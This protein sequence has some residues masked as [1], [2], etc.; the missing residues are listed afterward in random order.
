MISVIIPAHNAAAAIGECLAALQ[1]QTSPAAE[2][3]VIDD[4]STDN[5]AQL[6]A[7]FGVTLIR[8]PQQGP[9][10][11]RNAGI[12]A[13]RGDILCFTDADCQPA[14]DW[15]RE[16]TA[17]LLADPGIAAAKGAYCCRQTE[18]VARFVQI[19]YEDK[20]DVLRRHTSIAFMDFY[21]AACRRSVLLEMGG[22]DERFTAANTEDRDLSYRLAAR[23]Y[24]MVF[25][26]SALVCHYHTADFWGYVRKKTLNG[27][28]TMQS[29]RYFPARMKDDTYT[30]QAQKAQIGLMGAMGLAGAAALTLLLT[31]LPNRTAP[32]L[33]LTGLLALVFLL[34]AIPFTAKA[35]RKDR[36]IALISPVMLAVRALALGVGTAW[37]LL[38][39]V[40]RD[41]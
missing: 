28:W 8:Q 20:Y 26:P 7:E 9:A 11:A 38:R 1:R 31:G 32:C 6:A 4:G 29:V 30:P 12:R 15:L 22:F 10:S 19:E 23:G 18:P 2:I 35:W 39:P 33:A 5:T 40:R 17:P 3:I 37:G 25:R 13:A 24:K 16:I 34:T 36:R 14:P 41:A 27:Y 21:S